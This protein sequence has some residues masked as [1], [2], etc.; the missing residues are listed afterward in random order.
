MS[1]VSSQLSSNKTELERARQDMTQLQLNLQ[2][3]NQDASIQQDLQKAHETGKRL[4][5]I[6]M[7]FL[8]TIQ[9]PS[10]QSQLAM[11]LEQIS[12]NGQPQMMTP[13]MLAAAMQ[14][15]M[16]MRNPMMSAMNSPRGVPGKG[17]PNGANG[18]SMMQ[19]MQMQAMAAQV[20]AQAQAMMHAQMFPGMPMMVSGMMPGMPPGMAGLPGMMP[21]SSMA[22]MQQQYQQMAAAAAAASV[23]V[24]TP[25]RNPS[26]SGAASRTRTPLNNASATNS[27]RPTTQEP[28]IKEEEP[29]D[30]AVAV[31]ATTAATSIKQEENSTVAVA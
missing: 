28:T 4:E 9:D 20:Q 16:M 24:S 14:P 26:T 29:E 3:M 8:Q 13:P 6:A 25:S 2:Q 31:S 19:Q 1:S 15:H 30:V 21:P 7:K 10:Q 23:A 5:A 27:P 11:E 22:A 12:K 17:V 18:V